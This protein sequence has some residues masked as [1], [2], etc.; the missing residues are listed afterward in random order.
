MFFSK[1]L[2]LQLGVVVVLM[3]TIVIGL[4]GYYNY[5]T[6]RDRL[7]NDLDT[8]LAI[9]ADRLSIGLHAPLYTF[10][11]EG[12]ED[13]IRSEMR[14]HIVVGI[15]ILEEWEIEPTYA[16]TRTKD[17][18]VIGLDSVDEFIAQGYLN[19]SRKIIHEENDLGEVHVFMTTQ[20]MEEQLLGVMFSNIIQ[21]IIVDGVLIFMI[22]SLLNI[23]VIVPIKELK[24][25]TTEIA[26][27][28]LD[29]KIEFRSKD[30][31][32]Q[33][34]S[35]FSQ[36]ALNLKGSQE[37]VR[38]HAAEL[39]SKVKKRTAD[40]DKKV[41]ELTDT[42]TAV[43][44]MME[45]ME[46]TNRKLIETQEELEQSMSELK[47]MDIKKDQ[48]I[49]I[50]AHELK[51]PLTSIH[52]FAQLLQN[53]KVAN[54]FTKRNKYLK[55]MDH[56]TKRLA[57]LVGDILD[58]S[59][60]DLGTV[61]LNIETV[62]VN[63][64]LDEVKGEMEVVIK[65]KKLEPVFE[66]KK[67]PKIRT[68]RERLTQILINIIN[69]AVKYTQKGSVTVKAFKDNGDAHFVIKDTGIGISKEYQ[70]RIFDRFYQVDSSYT[71]K[72]SGTGLGLSLCKEFVEMLGGSIWV[73]SDPEKGSEFHF[74][75]PLKGVSGKMIR[76]EEAK[77]RE[78]IKKAKE[79]S[80]KMKTGQSGSG[81]S[82]G[83]G[84]SVGPVGGQ[85]N[86]AK[87]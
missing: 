40:L 65:G 87:K 43:L 1:S 10:H 35:A 77:A 4:F 62:D 82:G 29:T 53:R 86:G 52:G 9:T 70:E 11:S 20:Y 49:S 36:M 63:T 41:A 27:G 30:E 83:S 44:N 21:I 66:L 61:K 34:A 19:T 23:S 24:K 55:I 18:G 85:A 67:L 79:M 48:F 72:A 59:R 78:S 17:G 2:M 33:L 68:D 51:T 3:L 74:T 69:N 50:A 42:K 73:N 32:G 28:N 75:V 12:I 22:I 81:G 16:Y 45:D 84:N 6:E 31:I 58:L 26:R 46:E 13:V 8:S 5:V 47:E 80:E 64:L 25:A 54:E 37:D 56:E 60:I 76:K 14:N 39:E 7:K 71:R 38:K 57:N 15:Y